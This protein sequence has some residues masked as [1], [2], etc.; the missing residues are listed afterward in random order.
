M[1]IKIAEHIR[2]IPSYIPGK[3]PKELEHEMGISDAIKMASNEN[4]W[5][6]SPKAIRAMRS[7]L[8]GQHRY[9]D[10][11][12]IELRRGLAEK[13]D[14]S[15][16]EVVVGNGS[17]EIIELMARV[18]VREGDEVISSIPSFSLYSQCVQ[19]Q[20]GMNFRV[21]LRKYQHDLESIIDCISEKTKLVFLDNPNNPTGTPINPAKLYTFL[22]NIPE[23][24]IVVID[25]AYIDFT[26][27]DHKIDIF[28]L[29][30]NSSG[31][32]GVVFLRTFSKLY[33]LAGLRIG[34]GLMS[35]EIAEVLHRIRLPFN[36]N[37]MAQ[38][39]ALAAL[40]DQ[41][42]YD[43]LLKIIIKERER[44]LGGVKKLGLLVNP[45]MANFIM[46]DVGKDATR[47]YESMLSEGIIVRS[48]HGF[49]LPQCLRVSVGNEEQNSK[50]LEVFSRCLSKEKYV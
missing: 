46:I 10:A 42:Y 33:G 47:L 44:L 39:A 18:F 29:I 25:E 2:K 28:S 11:T 8:T 1:N 12:S 13:T 3:S 7:A 20:G 23:S 30:R 41:D 26:D 24:V 5:G 38:T 27:D 16:E 22:S 17:G 49:G 19:A 36:L 14:L 34:Y 4:P 40:T 32:C 6:A 21:E 43:N 31:R 48:L 50:F 9:P 15:A 45:S 35:A 37:Q